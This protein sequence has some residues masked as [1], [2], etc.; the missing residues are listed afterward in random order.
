MSEQGEQ[1]PVAQRSGRS[2]AETTRLAIALVAGGLIAVF[3][4][5]NTDE[6]EVNWI[7]GTA[8]TPLI[9]VIVVSLL[10]GGLVGYVIA[11]RGRARRK[12]GDG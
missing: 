4:L 2:N 6:V 5:L 3:A 1:K 9:L 7:L 8:Q 12:R 11:R 10:V